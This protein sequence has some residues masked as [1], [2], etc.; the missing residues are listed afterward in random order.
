MQRNII[1]HLI[2]WKNAQEHLPLLIR[3]ARQIGKTFIVEEFA[4]NHFDYFVNINFE[5]DPTFSDCFQTLN[6]TEIINQ[7]SLKQNVPIIPE[8][9][10]LF[11]DEIQN[12]PKAIMALRYFKEQLPKLHVIGAGS[13]LEFALND[14]EFRMPVGRIQY[15]YMYPLSFNEFVL[16]QGKGNLIA[17]IQ[18][19]TL[20]KPPSDTAHHELIKLLREYFI[21]GG[22]PAVLDSYIKYKNFA[23]CQNLQSGLLATYRNDFGKYAKHTQHAHLTTIFYKAV[24]L[25]GKKVKY[26]NIDPDSLSRD[27]KKAI[28]LLQKA[29][30]LHIVY[31]SSCSG[32]P[33]NGAINEKIFKL[34]FLDI[35]LV[36]RAG[37]IDIS[38]LMTNNNLMLINQGAL[39]EQF[40]GQELL[41][42]QNPYEE[43][44]AYF[45]TRDKRG[46]QAEVD[47]VINL[48]SHIVP[49]EVKA[50][51]K[52]KLK[53][54]KQFLLEKQ[55]NSHTY[56]SKIAIQISQQPLYFYDNIISLPLYMIS[57]LP[58][59]FDA[60]KLG[61]Y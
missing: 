52:G 24:Y 8:R 18:Q 7:L 41:S 21:L 33:L 40:V 37:K 15:L 12:C 49:I 5:F 57:E 4:K 30:I 47:Y 36:N 43:A 6:P 32:L 10:L 38:D 27:I 9:T 44:E 25:L 16:A 45:W 55:S 26:S 20:Q 31:S 54:L 3:G 42:L 53:S 23:I 48:N 19:A 46:S 2:E 28:N 61:K 59:V 60:I 14:E 35:G 13:L 50:G 39:A 34:L 11:L 22:M 1:K 17:H 56:D 29:G 58:R 51:A